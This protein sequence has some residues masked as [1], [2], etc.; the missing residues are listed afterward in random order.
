MGW[1]EKRKRNGGRGAA[2]LGGEGAEGGRGGAEGGRGGAEGGGE[3]A[4]GG[5]GGKE[6]GRGGLGGASLPKARASEIET[7]QSFSR[8]R[9]QWNLGLVARFLNFLD[10]LCFFFPFFLPEDSK[11]FSL[12]HRLRKK[13]TKKFSF[14]S[15]VT[16]L[17]RLR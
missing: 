3:G 7:K 5:R 16:I 1:R 4:K 14:F 10:F 17:P 15:R 12:V 11:I 9:F 13:I 2:K 8:A 6:G